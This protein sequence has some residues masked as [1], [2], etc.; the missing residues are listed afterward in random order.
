MPQ[1]L[2]SDVTIECTQERSSDIDAAFVQATALWRKP[3]P[4]EKRDFARRL[5]LPNTSHVRNHSTHADIM[6]ILTRLKVG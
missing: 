1:L 2:G 5:L 4:G 3:E 6:Y